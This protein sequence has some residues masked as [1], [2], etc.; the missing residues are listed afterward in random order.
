MAADR[1]VGIY[2]LIGC[3][4]TG[5]MGLLLEDKL[6]FIAGN[7][8]YLGIAFLLTTVVLCLAEYLTLRR[9]RAHTKESELA[10]MGWLCAAFVGFTQGCAV[11]P[12]LSRSGSTIAGGMSVGLSRKEATRYSF[13]LSL[14]IIV[15]GAARDGLGLMTGSLVLP[16]LGVSILGFVVAGVSGY[17]AIVWMLRLVQNTQLYWFAAYTAAVGMLLIGISF[18]HQ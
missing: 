14:P 7:Y 5:P 9:Q 8:R 10:Q 3:A 17:F 16:P 1:R 15:A 6:G 18:I 13:M 2:L 11:I 4:V 12:G